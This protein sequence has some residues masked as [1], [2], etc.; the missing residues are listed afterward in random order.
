MWRREDSFERL[1]EAVNGKTVIGPRPVRTVVKAIFVS[2][3]VA[4]LNATRRSTVVAI[5]IFWVWA[6]NRRTFRKAAW[7]KLPTGGVLKI[8]DW[9]Q[10]GGYLLATGFTEVRDQIFVA[11]VVRDG[12]VL[13]D[14][15]SNIGLYGVTAGTHGAHVIAFDPAERACA[16]A[17]QSLTANGAQADV[18]PWALSDSEKIAAF[19]SGDVEARLEADGDR[20][21]QTRRLDAI[22]VPIGPLT[23]LKIDAEGHDFQVLGGSVHFLTTRK[24]VVIVEF[25]DE[26][27]DIRHLLGDL[28]YEFFDYDWRR[29]SLGGESPRTR[30]NLICIHPDQ[31]RLVADRVTGPSSTPAP[32]RMYLD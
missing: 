5:G 10:I 3:I 12:D 27:K 14:V 16:I 13:V 31:L 9:S 32:P 26:A 8:P 23:V 7:V 1:F 19:S 25:R 4:R 2:M 11:R 24:P 6:L 29:A 21:V 20:R 17:V 22:D 18:Y 15:G 30:G 28:G